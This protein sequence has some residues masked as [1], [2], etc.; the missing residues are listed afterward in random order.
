SK[1]ISLR[2]LWMTQSMLNCDWAQALTKYDCRPLTAVDG[3]SCLEVGTPFSL[4]DGSAINIYLKPEAQLVRISDNGDTMFQLGSL[5][6]DVWNSA[7]RSSLAKML[8][9]HK[10]QLS[11]KGEV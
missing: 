2:S 1:Q 9:K 10:V 4:P 6:I 11:P 7:V 3:S 5:G 8:G